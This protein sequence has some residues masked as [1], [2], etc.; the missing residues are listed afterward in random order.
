MYFGGNIQVFVSYFYLAA[1]E[2]QKNWLLKK[3]EGRWLRV[4]GLGLGVEG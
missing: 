3:I 2:S 1:K 4:E